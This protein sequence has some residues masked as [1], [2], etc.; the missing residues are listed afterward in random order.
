[1]TS[2]SRFH[3]SRI[4]SGFWE[5]PIFDRALGFLQKKLNREKGKVYK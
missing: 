2:K 3:K 5:K 1:M 4:P